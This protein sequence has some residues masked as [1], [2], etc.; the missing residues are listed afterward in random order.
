MSYTFYIDITVTAK[1]DS[2]P[3]EMLEFSLD[4]IGSLLD[5]P[6]FE[7]C[8]VYDNGHVNAFGYEE[9]NHTTLAKISSKLDSDVI[10]VAKK[11]V[12]GSEGEVEILYCNDGIIKTPK[13]QTPQDVF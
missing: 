13:L 12:D 7:D 9:V 2:V 10:M 5:S 8:S 3:D 6:S 4:K 11:T 1:S